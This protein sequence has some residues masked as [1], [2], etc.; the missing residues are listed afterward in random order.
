M[1]RG[2][3]MFHC[4]QCNHNFKSHNIEYL[5]MPLSVPQRRPQCK[6]IRTMPSLDEDM[7]LV[8]APIWEEMEQGERQK[9][10]HRLR[11]EENQRANEAAQRKKQAK[12]RRHMSQKQRDAY[13]K[14]RAKKAAKRNKTATVI[15]PPRE[16]DEI[17]LVGPTWFPPGTPLK[18][19]E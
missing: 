9:E 19:E 18:V 5:M 8:Y 17:I 4:T 1:Y 16:K 7:I 12:K 11:L 2:L 14:K 6:S 10:A 15:E 3:T 13:D